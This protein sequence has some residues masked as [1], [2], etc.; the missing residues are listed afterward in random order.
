MFSENFMRILIIVAMLAFVVTVAH[1]LS[2]GGNSVEMESTERRAHPVGTTLSQSEF[3]LE[4]IKAETDLSAKDFLLAVSDT[5]RFLE[6]P[7]RLL[8]FPQE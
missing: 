1:A 6:F 5:N 8:R 2:Q 4:P 3:I 7:K